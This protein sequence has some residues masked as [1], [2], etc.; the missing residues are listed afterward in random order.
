VFRVK[1]NEGLKERSSNYENIRHDEVGD[2]DAADTVSRGERCI[3]GAAKAGAGA[4][5]RRALCVCMGYGIQDPSESE[6]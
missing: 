1:W 5:K 2:G 6:D 4:A 3:R